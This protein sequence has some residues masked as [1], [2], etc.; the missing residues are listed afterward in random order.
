M[1]SLLFGIV[2]PL[3]G[4]I[5]W[6]GSASTN[7]NTTANWD[8]NRVP[9]NA[10]DVIF[11]AAGLNKAMTNDR[12]ALTLFD[13]LSFPAPG[14]S[15]AGANLRFFNAPAAVT[16]PGISAT[17]TSGTTT[18]SAPITLGETTRF[19]VLAG[20]TLALS[21]TADISLAASNLELAAEGLVD[22]NSTISGASQVTVSGTGAVRM[23][24]PQSFGN[25]VVSG[26]L[27]LTNTMTGS[28]GVTNTGLLRGTGTVGGNVALVG[29]I[30]PG[31]TTATGR[32]TINGDLSFTVGVNTDGAVFDLTSTT[33]AT[34]YDQLRVGGAVL[35]T[36]GSIILRP[37]T[38]FPIG[39][40]FVLIDKT[41]V[42]PINTGTPFSG[43]TEGTIQVVGVN[44][45]QF[46]YVGGDGNDF[47]ATVVDAVPALVR[48]W[49][50]GAP[51]DLLWSG[52][53][54]W[55]PNAVPTAGSVLVFGGIATTDV[56]TVN[57]I[58]GNFSEIRFGGS[59]GGF[60][61]S[62]LTVNGN[63]LTVSDGITATHSGAACTLSNNLSLGGN[64][65][66]SLLG[67]SNLNITG[68]VG[69]SGF[70]LTTRCD[71]ASGTPQLNLDAR[72]S[73]TGNLIKSGSGLVQLGGTGTASNSYTGTTTVLAGE[74]RLTRGTIV[75]PANCIPG[76]LIIGG[77]V[78]PA[79]ITSSQ[80]EKIADTAAVSVNL[81]GSF[82]PGGDETVGSLNLNGGIVNAGT[83]TLTIRGAIN[84]NTTSSITAAG[85]NFAGI[86]S[87]S[88]AAGI[89]LTLAPPISSSAALT[90]TGP[91]R[92]IISSVFSQPGF[93]I[94]A[95]TVEMNGDS[96]QSGTF[97]LQSAGTL[98][99]EGFIEAINASA[100]GTVE[101]LAASNL[102]ANTFTG[103]A[104]AI[105][106]PDITSS[107]TASILVASTINLGN[108][109]L[110]PILTAAALVGETYVILSK[111]GSA[112][113]VTTR[114]TTPAGAV[115]APNAILKLALGHFVINYS[116][117]DGNDITLTAVQPADS[118]VT[119]VWDGGDVGDSW[120][121]PLNWAGDIAPV[122]GDSVEFPATSH[123]A[124]I[125]DYPAGLTLG[126]IRFTGVAPST[127]N[128]SLTG[129]AIQLLN[130]ISSSVTAGTAGASRVD[131]PVK[132]L[133]AATLTNTGTRALSHFQTLTTTI[134]PLRF[135]GAGDASQPKIDL[136]ATTSLSGPALVRVEGNALLNVS[137]SATGWTGGTVVERGA[138]TGPH[139]CA[140]G[141]LTVG[142]GTQTATA[143][144]SGQNQTFSNPIIV[145]ALGSLTMDSSIL[146]AVTV[147]S[148]SLNMG[149]PTL[150]GPLTLNGTA[151]CIADVLTVAEAFILNNTA[152]LTATAIKSAGGPRTLSAAAGASITTGT[153]GDALQTNQ[154]LLFN[155]GGALHVT[156]S[157]AT[158][159]LEIAGSNFRQDGN[160][161]SPSG[162]KGAVLLHGSRLTGS[163]RVKAITVS[164][165]G[166][167]V[168]PGAS[169]GL[170]EVNDGGT[171][172]NAASTL[173]MEING[174]L[175]GTG[176]DRLIATAPDMLGA[177]LQVTLSPAYTPIIGQQFV[178]VQNHRAAGFAFASGFAGISE[179]TTAILAPGITV[180]YSYLGG[181]GNDFS[182]TVTTSPAGAFRT[183]DGGGSDANWTTPANWL[184]D[185]APL[186]GESLLFP[187]GAAQL[188]ST[189][190]FPAT[191]LFNSLRLTG[192]Y[193]LA[194]G[195]LKL[196]GQLTANL[197]GT[198]TLNNVTF[199]NDDIT[200]HIIHL[201]GTGS[202]N[203]TGAIT[204]GNNVALTLRR[205]DP[206]GVQPALLVANI[207]SEAGATQP[208]V[209]V[210]GGGRVH[211]NSG[212]RTY[213]GTTQVRHGTLQIIGGSIPGDVAIGGGAGPAVVENPGNTDALGGRLNDAAT[214]TLLP[215]GT[216]LMTGAAPLE[217][218]RSV[219]YA[220]GQLSQTAGGRLRLFNTLAV[221]AGIDAPL[222]TPTIFDFPA[223]DITDA[224]DVG[225]GGIARLT[226]TVTQDVFQGMVLEKTGAG[227][228]LINGGSI[229]G[230]E[231]HI[232]QG[233][234][235][236]LGSSVTSLFLPVSL[237][238]GT[239]G[240]NGRLAQGLTATGAGGR[241]APGGGTDGLGIGTLTVG[242]NFLPAPQTSLEIELGGAQNDQLIVQGATVDLNNAA[243][244]V[245]RSSGF[246]PTLG[247]SFTILSKT[248]AG[249]ITRTF[250]GKPEGTSFVTAGYTWTI[251]YLG[252][253]GNDI[254]LTAGTAAAT[255]DLKVASFSANLPAAG[256]SGRQISTVIQGGS[257]AANTNIQLQFSDDL[258]NWSI[259]TSTAA[260]SS[261][262]ATF[263]ILDPLAGS[264]RFYRALIP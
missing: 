139:G 36:S 54:N 252:G 204:L 227:A 184:D 262:I 236:P 195:S 128:R 231:L 86:P 101:P 29:D 60:S 94:S 228:L 93:T 247:Q 207:L 126:S 12:P 230:T 58:G 254:V 84:A 10:E 242:G 196:T 42:G 192:N 234:V 249:A 232:N 255:V 8:L 62:P 19:S 52:A 57:D 24:A 70:D 113:P 132:F 38:E 133:S 69:L 80:N 245:T 124:A 179:G 5:V 115:L 45:F 1:A 185:I 102:E 37:S 175:P 35:T 168:A 59:V 77:G 75:A 55:S 44:A 27:V 240:G 16:L 213:T 15:V 263:E 78:N 39:T 143:V 103:G 111:P 99:G 241:V 258:I 40:N 122:A 104:T 178:L 208:G 88:V 136:F 21:S 30:D 186:P 165:S 215:G 53:A 73:G 217:R 206:L 163:G 146:A 32:L 41:S 56:A 173:Q 87:L 137:T 123:L 90:K 109:K 76:A 182:A 119:R 239:L 17:H 248:S 120:R 7:W 257:G 203:F 79:S 43:I 130:G 121:S 64:Q 46:S 74:L 98:S 114:F 194:T 131:L 129:N 50:G 238:G 199:L 25:A 6:D 72:L 246:F 159:S 187:A 106:R 14:Y 95:G 218:I 47:T 92:V 142:L 171:L 174:P 235:A 172:L 158:D 33:A 135:I 220:G 96:S 224:L 244:L 4:A 155:G 118:G 154:N 85:V 251:S 167:T 89:T 67:S 127:A 13:R 145:N 250:S 63:V 243:L 181:D 233:L 48:T 219:I 150:N 226:S 148:G 49:N 105:F 140:I 66:F 256:G 117:G 28:V 260:D 202:L 169:P 229:S 198:A 216:H 160:I 253:D 205:T 81:N 223:A 110:D 190:N 197:T 125:N 144:L 100:G 222:N 31:D 156:T 210:D 188:A 237:R 26:E 9:N 177:A 3:N 264:R 221:A 162:S 71:P 152:S 65:T 134:S 170:L 189:N 91:G 157:L 2:N 261:G 176:Y 147:N 153:L 108:M 214:L 23:D 161:P 83:K 138:L 68:A 51:T 149:S 180:R 209:I 201:E 212:N 166:G 20:G 191:T 200:D 97:T 211:F 164:I 193:T 112:N 141:G 225:T 183:W 22:V 18:F 61:I 11:P 116:G 259:L 151:T 107:S 82:L 34:G